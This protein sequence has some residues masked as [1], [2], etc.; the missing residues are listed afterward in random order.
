MRDGDRTIL[1]QPR[2]AAA[3]QH[4]S[5]PGSRRCRWPL[6]RRSCR[7]PTCC[8]RGRQRRRPSVRARSLLATGHGLSAAGAPAGDP[9]RGDTEVEFPD[10]TGPRLDARLQ[11]RCV[12]GF[13]FHMVRWALDQDAPTFARGWADVVDLEGH[14][15]LGACNSRAEVLVRRVV[16]RGT[17]HDRSLVQLVEDRKHGRTELPGVC[18]RPTPPDEISRKHSASSSCSGTGLSLAASCP[19]SSADLPPALPLVRSDIISPVQVWTG[20]RTRLYRKIAVGTDALL[21]AA[22]SGRG[23]AAEPE[24]SLNSVRIGFKYRCQ[25]T[26]GAR[27]PG[28]SSPRL[29]HGASRRSTVSFARRRRVQG[30][31][32]LQEESKAASGGQTRQR[33]G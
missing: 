28:V 23:K 5:P 2:L 27:T 29:S 30:L 12:L 16:V 20:V 4:R 31:T 3:S 32:T 21:R 18:G 9:G 22:P 8:R 14:L 24:P 11:D 7:P 26:L 1:R 17:E 10:P 33:C 19:G 13:R 25:T 6:R 15:E